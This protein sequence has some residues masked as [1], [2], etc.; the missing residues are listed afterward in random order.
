MN[1]DNKFILIILGFLIITVVVSSFTLAAKRYGDDATEILLP[2]VETPL[3]IGEISVDGAVSFPG[4]F[5]FTDE[6]TIQSILADAGVK[7][8][9]SL[10]QIEIYIPDLKL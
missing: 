2:Q 10:S 6:D 1:R 8:N 5:H 9:A 3:I 4:I 7:P